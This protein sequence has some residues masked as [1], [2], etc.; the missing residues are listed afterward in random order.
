MAHTIKQLGQARP[1]GITAESIYSPPADTESII[2]N[3]LIAN[4]SG[5]DATFR[6]FVDDNGTTY[7]EGTAI[8]WDILI[9][10]DTMVSISEKIT[11]NNSSGNLAVRTSVVQA[12]TFTVNGEEI[13][14]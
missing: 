11:M 8:A 2:H 7:D 4:T 12:L 10:A 14:E 9:E 1:T 3:I 5:A 13:T 6:L